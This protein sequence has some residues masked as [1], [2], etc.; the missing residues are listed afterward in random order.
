[1]NDQAA[2]ELITRA[3]DQ[4]LTA[5]Q[6]AVLEA[7]LQLSPQ[8]QHLAD[9][10]KQIQAVVE[11]YRDDESIG[12]LGPG[13]SGITRARLER[14]LQDELSNLIDTSQLDTDGQRRVAEDGGDYQDN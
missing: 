8:S 5:P 1:M 11:L 13:V 2:A 14:L 9:W 3:L 10:C 6:Q 7:H 4:P 12:Q